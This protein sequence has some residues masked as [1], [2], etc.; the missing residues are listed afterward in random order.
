MFV[1]GEI[2]SPPTLVLTLSFHTWVLKAYQATEGSTA[3]PLLPHIQSPLRNVGKNRAAVK[4]QG[5]PCS[6]SPHTL[7]WQNEDGGREE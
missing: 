4:S 6:G 5:Q 3:L 7:W 2:L 1:D